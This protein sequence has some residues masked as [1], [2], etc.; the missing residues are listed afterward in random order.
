M[1]VRLG[2]LTRMGS[3]P[4]CWQGNLL[5]ISPIAKWM[6]CS[7]NLSGY[8]KAGQTRSAMMMIANLL[9]TE[10]RTRTT[11]IFGSQIGKK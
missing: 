4:D 10:G 7:K 11:D 5:P 9:A 2:C 8:L 1:E 3:G 6:S